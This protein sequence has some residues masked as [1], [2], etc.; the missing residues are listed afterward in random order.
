MLGYGNGF[1]RKLHY[2]LENG[3]IT[4]VC[5]NLNKFYWVEG[6]LSGFGYC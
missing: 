4:I 6:I 1:M 2:K 3:G 5:Y